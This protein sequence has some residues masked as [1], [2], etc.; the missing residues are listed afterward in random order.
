MI[1][2]SLGLIYNLILRDP[3]ALRSNFA[4]RPE[5]EGAFDTALTG[6]AL[7][8]SV[9]DDEVQKLQGDGELGVAGKVKI[10]WK[11]ETMKELLQQ[12]RGQPQNALSLL[13]QA[14]QMYLDVSLQRHKTYTARG[15]LS[16]IRILLKTNQVVLDQVAQR[17]AKLRKSHPTVRVPNSIRDVP[18]DD[19]SS[20]YSAA[21]STGFDFDDELVNA[22]K[23]Y[24]RALDH[25][26]NQPSMSTDAPPAINM[27]AASSGTLP[28]EDLL[29]LV[30]RTLQEE[31]QKAT[32]VSEELKCTSAEL[33]RL[34]YE[35]AEI[36]NR[37]NDEMVIKTNDIET[38]SKDLQAAKTSLQEEQQK[39]K[40][41]S[42]RLPSR[43]D[44]SSRRTAK[45]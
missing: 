37:M 34:N 20:V 26:L 22:A 8:F 1:S 7:I 35:K 45:N 36:Q 16:D 27:L 9:L 39:T 17:S 19:F 2:A 40:I 12:I 32:S 38:L 33:S 29:D 28:A 6:C 42:K 15:S 23:V 5:L 24:R 30:R 25:Q 13:T 43:Q 11:D 10:V 4:T 41:I 44:D 21:T 18:I 3:E 14:L 31:R